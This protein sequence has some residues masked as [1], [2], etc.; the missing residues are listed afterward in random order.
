MGIANQVNFPHNRKKHWNCV[1]CNQ[2]FESYEEYKDHIFSKHLGN[3]NNAK[4]ENDT[5]V[6]VIKDYV[7]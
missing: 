3:S 1:P 6:E 2:W 7:Q 4:K 5:R